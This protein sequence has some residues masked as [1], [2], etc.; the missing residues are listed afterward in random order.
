MQR[1]TM[2]VTLAIVA[3]IGPAAGV[4]LSQCQLATILLNQGISNNLIPDCKCSIFLSI[5]N[6]RNCLVFK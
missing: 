5:F 6:E 3:I 1:Q 4:I 2:I